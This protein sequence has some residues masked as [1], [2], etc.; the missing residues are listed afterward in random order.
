MVGGGTRLAPAVVVVSP[1]IWIVAVVAGG[2]G[3]EAPV[4]SELPDDDVVEPADDP[5]IARKC[6]SFDPTLRL[7]IDFEDVATFAS[8]GSGRAHHP[9]TADALTI[10][11]RESETAVQMSALSRLR[12]GETSD[13]DIAP[14]LTLSLWMRPEAVP[15]EDHAYTMIDNDLQ[16]AITYE[17][18]GK[19]RCTIGG[20][21]VDSVA[22]IAPRSWYAVGC[23][24][25]GATIKLTID[26]HVAGCKARTGAVSASGILGT[27]IG[28]D[29]GGTVT[30]PS[31]SEP[32][33]GGLDNL[34]VFARAWS[35]AELCT[36]AGGADCFDVCP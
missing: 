25:D 18:N 5:A 20:D 23:T 17:D 1:R 34:Q 7:C 8:D 19:V 29:L 33:L 28:A 15:L 13:L 32:F 21:K 26:G 3:F 11:T 24:Y 35:P 27:A 14:N 6:A 9:M 4:E 22:P 31:F 2:C 16:Y 10:V 30:A 36:A 12:I